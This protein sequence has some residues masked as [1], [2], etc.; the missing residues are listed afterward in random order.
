[1]SFQKLG[2]KV[3]CAE[4]NITNFNQNTSN[5]YLRILKNGIQSMFSLC[6]AWLSSNLVENICFYKFL[7]R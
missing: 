6:L 5:H 2:P 7:I 4:P 3:G 1:M